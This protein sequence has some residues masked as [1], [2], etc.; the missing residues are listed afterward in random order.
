M[1]TT[2]SAN[3][4]IQVGAPRTRLEINHRNFELATNPPDKSLI[5]KKKGKLPM[6]AV[7]FIDISV[8]MNKWGH[9]NIVNYLTKM[10]HEFLRLGVKS[11]YVPFGYHPQIQNENMRAPFEVKPY[12]TFREIMDLESLHCVSCTEPYAIE[13]FFLSAKLK[14]LY[15]IYFIGDGEFTRYGYKATDR[16]YRNMRN[17]TDIVQYIFK[18]AYSAKQLTNCA[19]VTCIYPHH[20][21][22]RHIKILNDSLLNVLIQERKRSIIF[23]YHH[24]SD[25]NDQTIYM[26]GLSTPSCLGKQ[27]HY[28]IGVYRFPKWIMPNNIANIIEAYY[29][30]FVFTII[31]NMIDALNA[32]SKLLLMDGSAYTFMHRVLSLLQ[33]RPI[34]HFIDDMQFAQIVQ[35]WGLFW[36]IPNT[37]TITI[38]HIYFE[39]ID[40]WQI[41]HREHFD[42]INKL[43]G[44]AFGS[45]EEKDYNCFYMQYSSTHIIISRKR[46]IVLPST[47]EDLY[48]YFMDYFGGDNI[49]VVKNTRENVE[50]FKN[51]ILTFVSFDPKMGWTF[52]KNFFK[53]R[54]KVEL[55]KVKAFL[56][57]IALSNFEDKYPKLQFCLKTKRFNDEFTCEGSFKK[58]DGS[59]E[60]AIFSPTVV[61]AVYDFIQRKN[62]NF[63]FLNSLL[64]LV[65]EAKRFGF[66][67]DLLMKITKATVRMVDVSQK[68]SSSPEVGYFVRLD[69][70]VFQY[71][72]KIQSREYTDPL[73]MVPNFGIIRKFSRKRGG[74]SQ[75][76][77]YDIMTFQ[78]LDHPRQEK[79]KSSVWNNDHHSFRGQ[80][81]INTEQR[82]VTI[83]GKVV[84]EVYPE[85]KLNLNKQKW[86]DYVFVQ[87]INTLLMENYNKE[88]NYEAVMKEIIRLLEIGKDEIKQDIKLVTQ[89]LNF[90]DVLKFFR[91]TPNQMAFLSTNP[92]NRR[93]PITAYYKFAQISSK[94]EEKTILPKIGTIVKDLV[95][96]PG[97]ASAEPPHEPITTESLMEILK[98]S[99]KDI[100]EEYEQLCIYCEDVLPINHKT[101]LHDECGQYERLCKDCW[102]EIQ[103]EIVTLITKGGQVNIG[104]FSCSMC[105][106]TSNYKMK[107]LLG[108]YKNSFVANYQS[109]VKEGKRLF[110]CAGVEGGVGC[111]RKQIVSVYAECIDLATTKVKCQK[112]I[113]EEESGEPIYIIKCPGCT[114][115]HSHQ[116][117]TCN[118]MVCCGNPQGYH[119]HDDIPFGQRCT[120]CRKGSGYC[121]LRFR[122]SHDIQKILDGVSM[123][124]ESD[125]TAGI[126]DL[127][128][129]YKGVPMLYKEWTLTPVGLRHL[130][131]TS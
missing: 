114:S 93:M 43:K 78:Y 33:N 88:C 50:K 82:T 64:P 46:K 110:F 49:R 34:S 25:E 26:K 87:K 9:E 109:A 4:S 56:L 69:A 23:S 12:F 27:N 125:Y 105:G 129:L 112:C 47:I 42:N 39:P 38:Q 79:T 113:E 7:I 128:V 71:G 66:I 126:D 130:S 19:F 13:E 120:H 116:P 99:L 108:A 11:M 85:I 84:G 48:Q 1:S 94:N 5:S 58:P 92:F 22:P 41:A 51:N 54:A 115:Y 21:T 100:E 8:S 90:E 15:G 72:N 30:E 80:I 95:L 55:N 101:L 52:L 31:M 103:Q 20:T 106:I 121:G 3:S 91:F 61:S 118:L 36:T 86:K 104:L 32:D 14:K 76:Y 16:R 35:K 127:Y 17:A 65:H 102:T 10:D 67:Q 122:L 28:T 37:P 29:P 45:Q 70:E 74:S 57:G 68:S 107:T 111:S 75:K 73:P 63:K 119:G 6:N 62:L 98:R 60:K 18:I 2:S 124:F 44:R 96:M 89:A 59:W 97:L 77:G 40:R 81:S 117:G 53:K 83:F 123:S 131:K 24:L